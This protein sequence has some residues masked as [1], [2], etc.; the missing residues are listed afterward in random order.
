MVFYSGSA[1][2]LSL[3][4]TH[5]PPSPTEKINTFNISGSFPNG[6]LFQVDL[7]GGDAIVTTVGDGSSGNWTGTGASWVGAPDLS[8]WTVTFDA[9]QFKGEIVLKSV[10]T[11]SLVSITFVNSSHM[12]RNLQPA[13]VAGLLRS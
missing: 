4:G 2:A 7:V 11:R 3:S 10:S 9:P 1:E 5:L 12:N 8:L 6:T 13:M